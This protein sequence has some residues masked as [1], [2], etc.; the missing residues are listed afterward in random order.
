MIV[1]FAITVAAGVFDWFVAVPKLIVVAG[2]I[3]TVGGV[4]GTELVQRY[5]VQARAVRAG[6]S[7]EDARRIGTA[8][9]RMKRLF[10]NPDLT[11]ASLRTAALRLHRELNQEDP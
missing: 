8:A 9:R 11:E 3:V 2:V 5:A 7:R 4:I 6:F 10:E 1:S